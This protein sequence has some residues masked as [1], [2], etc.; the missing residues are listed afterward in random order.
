MHMFCATYFVLVYVIVYAIASL[1]VFKYDFL[2]DDW[3][4]WDSYDADLFAYFMNRT[5]SIEVW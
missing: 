1:P 5:Y 4:D 2:D 3:E